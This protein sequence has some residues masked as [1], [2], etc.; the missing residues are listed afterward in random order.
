MARGGASPGVLPPLACGLLL[1]VG[2]GAA[3]GALW[4]GADSLLWNVPTRGT[5]A[6]PPRPQLGARRWTPRPHDVA[7]SEAPL[8]SAPRAVHLTPLAGPVLTAAA[9]AH[10]STAAPAPWWAPFVGC[11][12]AAAAAVALRRGAR[13]PPPEPPLISILA[14]SGTKE[15]LAIKR[16]LNAAY[17]AFC[18]RLNEALWELPFEFSDLETVATESRVQG[19]RMLLEF[20]TE[21]DVEYSYW[22]QGIWEAT[23]PAG[24]TTLTREEV[25][26]F[27]TDIK[28]VKVT[29]FAPGY[30]AADTKAAAAEVRH[31]PAF[32]QAILFMATVFAEKFIRSAFFYN[33]ENRSAGR[34][35]ARKVLEQLVEEAGYLKTFPVHVMR[36]FVR[37]KYKYDW[38]HE[39]PEFEHDS[40]DEEAFRQDFEAMADEDKASL[41]DLKLREY[42][43]NL[44]R[45]GVPNVEDLPRPTGKG[46]VITPAIKWLIE[47]K[48]ASTDDVDNFDWWE[49]GEQPKMDGKHFYPDEKEEREEEAAMQQEQQPQPQPL[50]PQQQQQQR[51]QQPGQAKP[52][53]KA[54]PKPKPKE[55]TGGF[56][57]DALR[58]MEYRMDEEQPSADKRKA[59]EAQY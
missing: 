7:D 22:P 24:H 32:C 23:A 54:R 11:A 58:D 37:V 28:R 3:A 19:C 48:M 38:D 21:G 15:A 31:Q 36:T 2:A 8:A 50:E 13:P 33:E 52:K 16:Q 20:E 59:Q 14:T 55:K 10:P 27:V 47:R 34:R 9:A 4:P 56:N 29:D 57:Y 5:V 25:L 43:E 46:T 12:A 17:W 53:A 44:V 1:A 39:H 26:K 6:A 35:V 42:E 18:Y 45:D 41:E 49:R 51:P 30:T 40:D